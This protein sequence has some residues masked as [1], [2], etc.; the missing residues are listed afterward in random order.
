MVVGATVV[1]GA[2]AGETETE[3]VAAEWQQLKELWEKN[4]ADL[5]KRREERGQL[6]RQG[7]QLEAAVMSHD[8]AQ[9]KLGPIAKR[10]GVK[11]RAEERSGLT[12]QIAKVE[13]RQE[14]LRQVDAAY[15]DRKATRAA[16]WKEATT[17]AAGLDAGL[18]TGERTRP[19]VDEFGIST[20]AAEAYVS[21]GQFEAARK[22]ALEQAKA[23]EQAQPEQRR[24]GRGGPSL[25]L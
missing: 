12:D 15:K 20:Q 23:R 1:V 3:R 11:E 24:E 6:T 22:Q 17:F 4:L 16:R 5:E 21:Y 19:V 14:A 18:S 13:E 7:Q 10:R 2:T 25:D 8:Q 9:A